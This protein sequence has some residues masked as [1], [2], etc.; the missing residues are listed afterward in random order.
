MVFN[1]RGDQLLVCS[2]ADVLLFNKTSGKWKYHDC[3]PRPIPFGE[4]SEGDTYPI[5]ATGLDFLENENECLIGYLYNGFWKF[6]LETWESTLY[7]GPDESYELEE[8]RRY[9]G[10]ITASA[11]SPDSKSVVATDTC[12]GLTWFKV[13]PERLKKMSQAVIMGTTKGCALIL[14]VKRAE[15][16][17]ALKHGNDQTW[18]TSL[19][20]IDIDG[21]C[22]MIATGDG[23][24]EQRTRIILWIE[25]DKKDISFKFPKLWYI[26]PKL[27]WA[28]SPYH[29]GID[30]RFLTPSPLW[31]EAT[32]EKFSAY[33]FK[34]SSLAAPF[35]SPSPVIP[36]TSS[37]FLTKVTK[38]FDAL[39]ELLVRV[40]SPFTGGFL[41]KYC[42][43]ISETVIT[44]I[45]GCKI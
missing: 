36:A 28:G 5:V 42:Q 44:W 30:L 29:D 1:Q 13:M 18:V 31:S 33:F 25:E 35:P 26:M 43:G 6:N 20:Y 2:G 21:R 8:P 16:L 22:R 34:S 19:A 9:F 4:P 41:M 3:L 15:K 23:N 27:N 17:Q 38:L 24:C 14:E 11:Q 32:S 12:I 37:P 7:F 45:P 10:R 40:N 39:G